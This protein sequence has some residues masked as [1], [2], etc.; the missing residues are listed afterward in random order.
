MMDIEM[1][2]KLSQADLKD[3]LAKELQNNGYT[4]T[5][6]DG[7]LYAPGSVPVLLVAHFDTVHQ[8]APEIICYSNDRR[9]IMSP[10][11]I[12]GDDRAGV[13]MILQILQQ[14][15][16]YVLF[17]ED[18]EIGGIGASKFI[19]SNIPLPVYYII[20]VDRQGDND[21]VYYQCDNPEFTTF[22]DEFGF[23]SAHGSFS[24]ISIIAPHYG[25]AAV[26]IS[27]GYYNAHRTHEYIDM[28]A[29]QHNIARIVEMVNA[30]YGP[31]KYI[32][33][34]VNAKKSKQ[35]SIFDMSPEDESSKYL[36]PLPSHARLFVS[37]CEM[38]ENS[39]YLMDKDNIIYFY[40]AE[41]QAAVESLNSYACDSSG[42]EIRF[43]FMNARRTMILSCEEALQK[44]T[45]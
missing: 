10:Q 22:V 30:E 38:P 18:E 16:C 8:C 5:S 32:D 24:D 26:N 34:Q 14:T 42:K 11:G 21:A 19:K 20:E 40:S 43:S 9:Y 27:S 4:V 35:C 13:Y 37:D 6:K 29:V 31:F 2:L 15:K 41:L 25:I 44:L 36:M 28:N 1:I 33:W 23:Q 12:G 17:C 39:G 7:F 45:A 3:A